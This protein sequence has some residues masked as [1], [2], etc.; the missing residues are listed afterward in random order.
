MSRQTLQGKENQGAPSRPSAHARGCCSD[1]RDIKEGSVQ[2]ID[3]VVSRLRRT[4]GSRRSGRSL[5]TLPT[6]LSIGPIRGM[7]AAV[8]AAVGFAA[9]MT[10]EPSGLQRR[11]L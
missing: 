4:C 7:P 8:T 3:R 1:G 11:P 2:A 5:Q 10:S 9:R 6:L